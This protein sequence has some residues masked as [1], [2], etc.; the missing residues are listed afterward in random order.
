M[1]FILNK[2]N[3]MNSFIKQATGSKRIYFSLYNM[4][5]RRAILSSESRGPG[6]NPDQGYCALF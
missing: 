2:E 3:D 4:Y 1:V 5:G 6:S